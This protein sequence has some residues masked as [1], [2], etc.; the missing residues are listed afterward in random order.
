[1]SHHE[2]NNY[3]PTVLAD[4]DPLMMPADLAVDSAADRF[5]GTKMQ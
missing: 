4:G 3:I 1:M 2:N 5:L